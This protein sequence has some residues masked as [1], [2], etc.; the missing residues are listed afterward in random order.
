MKRSLIF[1]F[2]VYHLKDKLTELKFS[3]AKQL[4]FVEETGYD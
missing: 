4:D 2:S 1:K 3:F